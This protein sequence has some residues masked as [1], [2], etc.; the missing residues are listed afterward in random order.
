[1]KTKPC[2]P[3]TTLD[4]IKAIHGYF[5]KGTNMKMF[6]GI[7]TVVVTVVAIYFFYNHDK[8]LKENLRFKVM[9]GPV[10]PFRKE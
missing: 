9:Y 2:I 5:K 8:K 3:G 10:G 6:L 1:M 4:L 7:L